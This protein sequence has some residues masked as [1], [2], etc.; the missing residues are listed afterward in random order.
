MFLDNGRDLYTKLLTFKN[1][2]K[3]IENFNLH[4]SHKILLAVLFVLFGISN[5]FF[6]TY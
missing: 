4:K 5:F 3:K 1:Y 2:G 6:E